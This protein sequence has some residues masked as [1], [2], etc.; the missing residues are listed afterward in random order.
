[1]PATR[2]TD[3]ALAGR[4]SVLAAGTESG[5]VAVW[6]VPDGIAIGPLVAS[7]NPINCLQFGPDLRR[8]P[9]DCAAASPGAGWLLAAGDAGSDVTVWDLRDC[10]VLSRCRGS[11]YQISSLAFSPDGMTL[12]SGGRIEVKLWNLFTGRLLL[13]LKEGNFFRALAFS[14]D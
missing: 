5:S 12:A 9:G 8:R 7:H 10:T 1:I 4:G 2:P 14:P 3:V 13:D 11:V 6:T